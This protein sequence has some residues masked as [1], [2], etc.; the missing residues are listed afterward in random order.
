[1]ASRGGIKGW[2]Q[3][4]ALRGGI[5]RGVVAQIVS[6]RS[7]RSGGSG[8]FGGHVES[9]G[10]SGSS[11]ALA[12]TSHVSGVRTTGPTHR[13]DMLGP[14]TPWFRMSDG[15]SF[16]RSSFSI[17]IGAHVSLAG[18]AGSAPCRIIDSIFG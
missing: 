2:H 18:G 3:E 15:S 14:W 7:S 16:S 9:G 10:H 1:M 4:V 12:V 11:W 5:K 8:G 13:G 17:R 6:N